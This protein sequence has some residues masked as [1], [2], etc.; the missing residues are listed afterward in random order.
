MLLDQLP[1]D[2]LLLIF[3][4]IKELDYL[5]HIYRGQFEEPIP[6]CVFVF[7]SKRLSVT[8]LAPLMPK[9][10]IIDIGHPF[11]AKL[12]TRDMIKLLSESEH[13]RG[14]I[15]MPTYY[16]VPVTQYVR[17]L[18]MITTD[19][20]EPYLFERGPHIKQLYVKNHNLNEVTCHAHRFPNLLRLHIEQHIGNRI[21]EK[22]GFP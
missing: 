2:C 14:L 19:T 3:K 10:R 12:E 11:Y 9:L 22:N 4:Q 1:D 20:L 17:N 8:D 15:H 13:L 5:C 6:K 18:E 16:P 21:I 7:T